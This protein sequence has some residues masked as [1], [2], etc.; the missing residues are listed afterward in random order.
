MIEYSKLNEGFYR[1]D[2]LDQ[3]Q[4]WLIFNSI[5]DKSTSVKVASYKYGLLYSI[6]SLLKSNRN[7]IKFKFQEI[8][9]PFIRI[10]WKL[11]VRYQLYQISANNL[12]SIYKILTKFVINHPNFRMME[13]SD[14][15]SDN[16]DELVN[17][18][19]QKCSRNVFGALFGDSNEFFYNFNKREKI[20]ELNPQFHDFLLKYGKI[21]GK[22]NIYEWIK[23][24]QRRNP[25]RAIN[26]TLFEEV[27]GEFKLLDFNDF[28]IKIQK[29]FDP[30]ITIYTLKQ[31]KANE[32]LEINNEGILVKTEKAT[33]LVKIDLIKKAWTNL[34]KDGVLYRDEHDKSTYRSSFIITL[35]SQFDFIDTSSKGRLSIK[36]KNHL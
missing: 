8:F 21:I 15:I 19:S 14:I 5:F 17:E 27:V 26:I 20:I 25:E 24:L 9:I 7:Q 36:L 16:K 34:I 32:I 23:F 10:Y 4:I 12:S 33:K 30:P 18:V 11:I 31:H 35:L 6:L 22:V 29:K 1:K 2:V 13:F 28:W 3:E